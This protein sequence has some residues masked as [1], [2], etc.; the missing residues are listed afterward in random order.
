MLR[1]WLRALIGWDEL[2]QAVSDNDAQLADDAAHRAAGG[3]DRDGFARLEGL[4][5]R[6]DRIEAHET[7]INRMYRRTEQ[8]TPTTR[9]RD[10]DEQQIEFLSNPD[11][12]KEVN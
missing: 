2:S 5:A 10:W 12:F 4:V 11:N 3:A 7:R 8:S 1:K 6:F 9:V